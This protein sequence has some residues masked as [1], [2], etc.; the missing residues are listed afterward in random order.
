MSA[1]RRSLALAAALFLAPSAAAAD[2]PLFTEVV[3]AGLSSPT[4]VVSP[5]GDT[6]RLFVLQKDGVVRLVDDGVLLPTPF[7]DLRPLVP[8]EAWNGLLGLAFHPDFASNGTFYVHHPR[9]LTTSDRLTIA[10][11]TLSADPDVADPASRDEILVLPYPGIPGHHLG[12]WIG[13]GPDGYLRVPLGDGHTTGFEAGG[14][15]RA[16][17]LASPWGKL[18]RI[19][20][21]GDDFPGDPDRDYAIPPDNPYVGQGGDEAVFARGLRQPYRAC[22]DRVTGDLWIA[23]VG[24]WDREE[25]DFIAAGSPGGQDFGWDCTEGALCTPNGNCDCVASPPTPPLYDYTHDDGCS[26]AGGAVYHGPAIPELDGRFF[27]GDWCTNRV[28]SVAQSGGVLVDV[29]EHTAELSPPGG[30]QSILSISEGGDG[31]LY[32]TDDVAVYRVVA[33]R[34]TDLGGGTSGVNGTLVATGTGP[35]TPGS[36]NPVSL[37]GA[38]PSALMLVWIALSPGPPFPALGG[39]VHAFPFNS[40]LFAFSSP[41]G[42]WSAAAPWPAG[43]PSGTEVRFQFLADD[44]TTLHDITLSNGLLATTP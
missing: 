38:P 2:P 42:T 36:L 3:A 28:W 4:A 29:V 37:T 22:F 40:Q 1:S 18:L 44:P 11:Y 15:A 32:I 25:I 14:G 10:R 24:R 20:V 33:Q 6:T 30:F 21:D 12:G 16:Q 17:D 27:F 7:L 8:E 35:L 34:W 31:E 5:P 41:A 23:E 13:F 19:D 43:V 39:V 9:G 26:I